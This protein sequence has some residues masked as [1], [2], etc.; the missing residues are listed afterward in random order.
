[1]KHFFVF[2]AGIIVIIVSYTVPVKL[3]QETYCFK[4]S[5]KEKGI[6]CVHSSTVYSKL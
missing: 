5:K 2:H 4:S 1:M 6:A 3:N